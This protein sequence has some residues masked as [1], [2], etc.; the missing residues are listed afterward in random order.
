[1]HVI[2]FEGLTG[3]WQ[4]HL[5]QAFFLDISKKTQAKKTQ[6]PQKTQAQILPKTQGTG[7]FML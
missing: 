7:G 2:V 4:K 1:M 5:V 6:V 3:K